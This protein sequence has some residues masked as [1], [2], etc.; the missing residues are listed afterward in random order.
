MT[1]AVAYKWAADPQEAQVGEDGTVDWSRAKPGVAE[2]DAV[3]VEAARL[4]A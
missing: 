4:L 2:Y 1:I 3:A